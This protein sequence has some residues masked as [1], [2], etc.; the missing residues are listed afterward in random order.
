MSGAGGGD[1]L[2]SLRRSISSGDSGRGIFVAL[3]A[4]DAA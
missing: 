3:S 2:S 4:P 1:S